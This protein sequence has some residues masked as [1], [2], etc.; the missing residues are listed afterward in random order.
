ADLQRA[1]GPQGQPGRPQATGQPAQPRTERG[2][3]HESNSKPDPPSP[4]KRGRGDGGE[5]SSPEPVPVPD[6][7]PDCLCAFPSP[8]PPP[9]PPQSGGRGEKV[10]LWLSSPAAPVHLCRLSRFSCPSTPCRIPPT[11]YPHPPH[12]PPLTRC[13]AAHSRVSSGKAGSAVRSSRG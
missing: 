1:A 5:G 13:S 7:V 10:P 8:P 2:A 3:V 6:P 4:P 9:P 12:V 11:P